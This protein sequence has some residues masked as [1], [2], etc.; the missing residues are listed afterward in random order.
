MVQGSI[1]LNWPWKP[2]L[3]GDDTALTIQRPGEEPV[4]ESIIS[5]KGIFALEIDAVSEWLERRECPMM[6]WEDSLGNMAALDAWRHAIGL[7]YPMEEA[8]VKYVIVGVVFFAAVAFLI[9]RSAPAG[10]QKRSSKQRTAS[11]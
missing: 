1:E 3:G 7:R 9:M 11:H 10:Y 8:M 4:I 2:E 5:E 6:N